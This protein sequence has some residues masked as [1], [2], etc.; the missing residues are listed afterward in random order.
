MLTARGKSRRG[1]RY[2]SAVKESISQPV[3]AKKTTATEASPARRA[4]GCSAGAVIRAPGASSPTSPTASS[5]MVNPMASTVCTRL[6]SRTPA[7]FTTPA[8]TSSAAAITGA[9]RSGKLSNAAK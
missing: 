3:K 6:D 1:L 5:P 8:P 2:S 9:V 4:S 7:M